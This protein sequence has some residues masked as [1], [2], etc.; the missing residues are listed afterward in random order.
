MARKRNNTQALLFR[1]DP[2]IV[3][4]YDWTM[5]RRALIY[6]RV[7]TEDQGRM[8]G[9]PSQ[10]AACLKLAKEKG[11]AVI[12][13]IVDDV[14]GSDTRRPGLTELRRL[15]AAGECEIVLVYNVDRLSRDLADLLNLTR[16][17]QQH[18]A[19]EYAT[20][21]F[22]DS[23]SGRLFLS[24]RGAIGAFE[25][26][27][28]LARTQAGRIAKARSGKVPGGRAPYGYRIDDGNLVIQKDEAKVV[29]QI[30]EWAAAGVSQRDIARRL[31]ERGVKPYRAQ[32]WGKTSVGRLLGHEVYVGT[33]LYNARKRNKTILRPRPVA[34]HIEIPVPPIINRQVYEAVVVARATNKE[35]RVGRPSRSYMLTG[36]LRCSCGSRMC[37]GSGSYRCTRRTNS[38]RRAKE[39]KTQVSAAYLDDLIWND[40]FLEIMTDEHRLRHV[41]NA[42][43]DR[44]RAEWDTGAEQRAV[45]ED[46]IAKLVAK[47]KRLLDLM[48]ELDAEDRAELKAKREAAR[49]ERIRLQAELKA[50]VPATRMPDIDK[51]VRWMSKLVKGKKTV[52]ERRAILQQAGEEVTWDGHFPTMRVHGFQVVDKPPFG[53]MFNGPENSPER[54][55]DRPSRLRQ[56]HARQAP[57]R[58]PAAAHLRGGH[59][60]H[61]SPQHRRNPGTRRRTPP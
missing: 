47:E 26:E 13:E 7:S 40:G 35:M 15:V 24:L 52:L 48:V 18:A 23:A 39:C 11:W 46:R 5:I 61:Q 17:L 36:L 59:R 44:I 2:I 32:Q 38:D 49:A 37:G 12:K 53:G 27:Q 58:H 9:L 10:R 57:R 28:I 42:A 14:T 20:E 41:Y 29:R 1:I 54:S 25:R 8:Y 60:N 6:L 3:R 50:L 19:I 56:D 51:W 16:E 33:A 31:N 34:E 30:Y 4:M 45:L 22:E 43:Q 55:H 21:T